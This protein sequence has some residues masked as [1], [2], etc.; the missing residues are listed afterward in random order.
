M[1]PEDTGEF[2]RY[3]ELRQH[4]ETAECTALRL[5]LAGTDPGEF[6]DAYQRSQDQQRGAAA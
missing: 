3:A 5:R 2:G 4:G 6:E 1:S